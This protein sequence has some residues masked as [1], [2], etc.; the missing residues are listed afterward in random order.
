[1]DQNIRLLNILLLQCYS[2]KRYVVYLFVSCILLC[3]KKDEGDSLF[4]INLQ[5]TSPTDIIEFE[6]NIL[7]K[8]N[9]EHPQGYIGFFDP[10]YLSLEVKYSRLHNPDYYHL[11]PVNPPNHTLSLTVEILVEIDAPF[12]FGNGSSETLT[13]TIRIEDKN[14]NWSNKVTTPIITVNKE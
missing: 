10:D 1:M 3:C 14:N 7:V 2:M 11:I 13:F 5:Q 8:I 12:V 9:Y 4:V 6:E